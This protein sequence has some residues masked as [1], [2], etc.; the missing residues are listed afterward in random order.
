M[1]DSPRVRPDSLWS[2]N[3]TNVVLECVCLDLTR[4]KLA[5]DGFVNVYSALIK[6]LVENGVRVV[7]VETF[8]RR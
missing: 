1:W 6:H 3:V 8:L 7:A 2:L 5:I 4:T